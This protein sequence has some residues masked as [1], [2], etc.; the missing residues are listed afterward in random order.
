MDKQ[1]KSSDEDNGRLRME[2]DELRA[3]VV[4]LQ[5]NLEEKE[6]EVRR[7]KAEDQRLAIINVMINGVANLLKANCISVIV[8]LNF[9]VQI[10][11][12]FC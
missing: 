12:L 4:K 3:R 1:L 5:T 2:R 10:C 11:F 7:K 8:I 9:K 6:G